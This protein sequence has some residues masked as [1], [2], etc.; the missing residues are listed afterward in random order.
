MSTQSLLDDDR[1]VDQPVNQADVVVITWLRELQLAQDG[2]VFVEA[3]G[4]EDA[5]AG[6]PVAGGLSGW[7][8]G[9]PGLSVGTTPA[10]P[11]RDWRSTADIASMYFFG[12]NV[13]V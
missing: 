3:D 2:I 9:G 7:T 5:G 4:V 1:P 8:T 11:L 12:P 10:D 6:D 13:A